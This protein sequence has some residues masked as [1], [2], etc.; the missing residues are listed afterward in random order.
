M[1]FKRFFLAIITGAL[2]GFL[3]FLLLTP[4]GK[5]DGPI[6]FLLIIS[7]VIASCIAGAEAI[8][9]TLRPEE[10]APHLSNALFAILATSILVYSDTY[11]EI[12]RFSMAAS[13]IWKSDWSRLFLPHTVRGIVGALITTFIL[14]LCCST[15]SV[16]RS[17]PNPQKVE[18]ENIES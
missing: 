1:D 7:T 16:I 18:K 15:F 9:K 2:C 11:L 8:P 4:L 3:I 14:F 6:T 12:Y 10:K 17:T 13:Y 5:K